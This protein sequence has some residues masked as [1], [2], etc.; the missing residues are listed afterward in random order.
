[1]KTTKQ[2]QKKTKKKQW[3]MKWQKQ[4]RIQIKYVFG[5]LKYWDSIS[6]ILMTVVTLNLEYGTKHTI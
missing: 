4:A 3:F 6:K 1:M 2:K 5:N